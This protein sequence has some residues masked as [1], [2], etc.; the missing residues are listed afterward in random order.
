MFKHTANTRGIFD[1]GKFSKHS[2]MVKRV[3]SDANKPQANKA[4][5]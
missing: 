1:W 4:S 3:V 5:S 2:E